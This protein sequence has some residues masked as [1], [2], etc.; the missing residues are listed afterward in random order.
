MKREV[1]APPLSMFGNLILGAFMVGVLA[2]VSFAPRVMKI[3]GESKVDV[4]KLTAAR[5]A[6]EAFP[7]WR[8]ERGGCPPSIADLARYMERRPVFDPWGEPYRMS[9][10]DN[11]ILVWSHGEDRIP[12]TTDD[13]WSNR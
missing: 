1:V 5:F 4:A 9:C 2:S 13:I 11:A 12:N 3:C 7:R 10:N 8:R 6:N